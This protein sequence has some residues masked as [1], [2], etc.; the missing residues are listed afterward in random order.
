MLRILILKVE[1]RVRL[2]QIPSLDLF[3]NG[4]LSLRPH[5][6]KSLSNIIEW[7]SKL[8]GGFA[9]PRAFGRRAAKYLRRHGHNYDCTHNAHLS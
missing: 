1:I 3:E 5:H 6:L 9:E 2:V 8:T 4:L 7:T